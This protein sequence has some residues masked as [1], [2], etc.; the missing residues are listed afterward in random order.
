MTQNLKGKIFHLGT[1]DGTNMQT[2]API[3]RLTASDVIRWN[4]EKNGEAEFWPSGNRPEVSMIFVYQPCVTGKD[5]V[6]LAYLLECLGGDSLEN[7]ERIQR[8]VSVCG[9]AF[10]DLI[11]MDSG[12]LGKRFIACLPSQLGEISITAS[13]WVVLD[14]DDVFSLLEQHAS[15]NDSGYW[16]EWQYCDR[17]YTR[18]WIYIKADRSAT[19]IY[20]AAER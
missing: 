17:N 3:E 1:F 11:V 6:H 12:E 19:N 20:L 14:H 16:L 9:I 7:F 13:A 4:V 10:A 2:G 8:A 18:F 5:L 15:A